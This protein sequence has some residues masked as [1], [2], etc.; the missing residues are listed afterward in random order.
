VLVPR[1]VFPKERHYLFSPGRGLGNESHLPLSVGQDTGNA[2]FFHFSCKHPEFFNTIGKVSYEG[3]P[4][5]VLLRFLSQ[6]FRPGIE[7][8]FLQKLHLLFQ[9]LFFLHALPCRLNQVFPQYTPERIGGFHHLFKNAFQFFSRY[10]LNAP[11]IPIFA[12]EPQNRKTTDVPCILNM[13]TPTG[14]HIKTRNFHNSLLLIFPVNTHRKPPG[15][16][17]AG[18]PF[19]FPDKRRREFSRNGYFDL[20]PV[21]ENRKTGGRQGV[22]LF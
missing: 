6:K 4:P 7:Q 19:G 3:F 20:H 15:D 18:L 13:Q 17:K 22:V 5:C 11:E 8:L 21:C 2:P 9:L 10:K 16:I 14:I 12:I 1:K